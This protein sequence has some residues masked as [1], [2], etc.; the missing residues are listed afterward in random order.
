[1]TNASVVDQLQDLWRTRPARLPRQ[2]RI[3][4]VAAGIG[5]R[6]DVDPLLVRVAFV[7]STIFGG[8]GIV[9]YLACWVVLGTPDDRVSPAESLLGRG[10]STMSPKRAAILIVVLAIAISTLTPIGA[11]AGGAGLISF[12]LMLGGLWLL[13][14][15]RP[16]PPELPSDAA[17]MPAVDPFG[18][19]YAPPGYG[20]RPDP[21]AAG[22]AP[23]GYPA[24]GPVPTDVPDDV[25][26]SDPALSDPSLPD[27]PAPASD[28]S[29]EPVAPQQRPTT[30]PNP[31]SAS[32]TVST[33]DTPRTPPAWDPLGM[34]PF[35]WDLPE[36]SPQTTTVPA[37]P[38]RRRSL[39]TTVVIG[40]AL[41]VAAAL[42]A[43]ASTAGADWFTPARIAAV[44]LAVIGAG[45]VAGAFLR[46]GYGLLIVAAPLAG[47]VIL[48]SLVGPIDTSGGI[49]DRTYVPLT[50]ADLRPSY[51]VA[52]G[53][54]T[55]DLRHLHLSGDAT[56]DAS[57]EVGDVEVLVPASMNVRNTCTGDIGDSHCLPE[58][59]NP[60]ADTKG[61][62]LTVHAKTRIGNV[63]VRRG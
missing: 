42:T 62:V 48:A 50:A 40:L 2:G 22:Y 46:T 57:A 47:F 59:L 3:A 38:A 10:V 8:A 34:A 54:L 41:L 33:G 51:H 63:E 16:A 52:A 49:G 12:T 58:G 18:A 17:P 11:G 30:P 43:L 20:P 28:D 6:Y 45:L 13:Y 14:Q 44:G 7:V 1:M 29:G 35:A 61:P 39:L 23:P 25:T 36:P 27:S 5:R 53:T 19:G 31:P 60:G 26:V 56:V 32:S 21:F 9:L 4:G 37:R 24:R 15:R 55:L